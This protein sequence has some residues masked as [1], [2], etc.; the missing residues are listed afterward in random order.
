[1]QNNSHNKKKK[2]LVI[3]YFIFYRMVCTLWTVGTHYKTYRKCENKLVNNNF[4]S[5]YNK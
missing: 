5:K 1:M 3:K 4:I 2:H